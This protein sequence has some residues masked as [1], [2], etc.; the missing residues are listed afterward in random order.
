PRQAALV[1]VLAHL[2]MHLGGDHHLVARHAEMLQRPAGDLLADAQR[3]DVGGVEEIDAGVERRLDERAGLGL[4]EH[5][6]APALRPVG[7]HAEAEA[8]DLEAGRAEIDV[9]HGVSFAAGD[10]KCAEINAQTGDDKPVPACDD[11]AACTGPAAT[12]GTGPPKSNHSS[13]A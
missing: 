13:A 5:P 3:I 12:L 7:H 2:A 6:V 11:R 4:V 10:W 9:L 8:G 1:W